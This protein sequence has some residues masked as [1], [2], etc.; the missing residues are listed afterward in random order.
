MCHFTQFY[1]VMNFFVE[2]PLPF[3]YNVSIRVSL[4]IHPRKE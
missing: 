2:I 1:I 3:V 4:T